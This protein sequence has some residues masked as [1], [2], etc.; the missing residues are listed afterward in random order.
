MFDWWLAKELEEKYWLIRGQIER[1]SLQFPHWHWWKGQGILQLSCLIKLL[2]INFMRALTWQIYLCVLTWPA[3][4]FNVYPS[5]I[6][7]KISVLSLIFQS[8]RQQLLPS[9]ATT[10]FYSKVLKI[11]F[12]STGVG[13]HQQNQEGLS[14]WSTGT[15][16]WGKI[17]VV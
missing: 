1:A 8:R 13:W 16:S 11:E 15:W 5:Q 3:N 17:V 6:N 9:K 12:S 7:S 4:L 10:S 2:S 14:L